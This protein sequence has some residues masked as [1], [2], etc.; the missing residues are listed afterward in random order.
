MMF[1]MSG[2]MLLPWLFGVFYLDETANIAR[3]VGIVLM[4]VSLAL[5]L[6]DSRG[7]GDGRKSRAA[8]GFSAPRYSF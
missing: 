2:G 7:K 8:T 6:L 4:L 5:P 3:V 1:L